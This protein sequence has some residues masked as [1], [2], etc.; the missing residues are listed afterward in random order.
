MISRVDSVTYMT[1]IDGLSISMGRIEVFHQGPDAAFYHHTTY[2][3][4][5]GSNL[6]IY[7]VLRKILVRLTYKAKYF[8]SSIQNSEEPK[9]TP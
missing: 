4:G 3:D 8:K 2:P 9:S 7:Q 6:K 1:W 5:V